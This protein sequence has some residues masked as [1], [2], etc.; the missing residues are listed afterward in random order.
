MMRSAKSLIAS[1][2]SSLIIDVFINQQRVSLRAFVAM[3]HGTGFVNEPRIAFQQHCSP[4]CHVSRIHVGAKASLGTEHLS[5]EAA[6][7]LDITVICC[8]KVL[9]Q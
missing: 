9:Y 1:I 4:S 5:S 6:D 8:P 2:I 7:P 3:K